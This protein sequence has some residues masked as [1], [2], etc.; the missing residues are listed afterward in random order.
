MLFPLHSLCPSASPTFLYPVPHGTAV[1]VSL[2]HL[3]LPP[4]FPD[5]F[6]S[7]NSPVL[8]SSGQKDSK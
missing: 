3:L 8:D 7:P 4:F 6:G 2:V 1:R 5:S